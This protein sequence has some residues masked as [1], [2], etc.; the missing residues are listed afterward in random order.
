MIMFYNKRVKIVTQ[1]FQKK[2]LDGKLFVVGKKVMLVVR[3][4]K[5]Q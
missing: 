5:N 4:D 2:I 1:Y 3:A